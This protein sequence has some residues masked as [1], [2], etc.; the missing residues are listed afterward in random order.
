VSSEEGLLVSKPLCPFRNIA[1]I[2]AEDVQTAVT[3][4]NVVFLI[5]VTRTVAGE[6]CLIVSVILLKCGGIGVI[7]RFAFVVGR[8]SLDKQRTINDA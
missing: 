6:R 1:A 7:F 5:I 8:P 2:I 4:L 3:V